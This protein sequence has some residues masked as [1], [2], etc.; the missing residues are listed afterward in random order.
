MRKLISILLII[1][2]LLIPA[3]AEELSATVWLDGVPSSVSCP[4]AYYNYQ[5]YEN[6][7]LGTVYSFESKKAG[8]NQMIDFSTDYKVNSG[9]GAGYIYLSFYYKGYGSFTDYLGNSVTGNACMVYPQFR[10]SYVLQDVYMDGSK[11]FKTNLSG[12]WIKKSVIMKINASTLDNSAVN[13]RFKINLSENF[14]IDIACPT[15]IYFNENVTEEEIIKYLKENGYYYNK[16][17]QSEEPYS[18][19]GIELTGEFYNNRK[20]LWNAGTTSDGAVKE[21][22]LRNWLN[23]MLPEIRVNSIL[24]GNYAFV[25][26]SCNYWNLT[27]KD[28]MSAPLIKDEN[29]NYLLPGDVAYSLFNAG[30]KSTYI[31]VD[32]IENMNVFK[33]HRGFVLISSNPIENVIDLTVNENGYYNSAFDISDAIGTITWNDI[34]PTE[35]DYEAFTS[36]WYE[37]MTYPEG[38]ESEFSDY[39]SETVSTAG[40]HLSLYCDNGLSPFSDIEIPDPDATQKNFLALEQVYSR[41]REMAI[42]YRIAVNTGSNA[43]DTKALKSAILN[44]LNLMHTKYY[45]NNAYRIDG[46]PRFTSFK[47]KLPEA[48]ADILLCMYNDLEYETLKKYAHEVLGRTVLPTVSQGTNERTDYTNRLWATVPYIKL[49]V[50]LKDEARINHAYRYLSQI[51]D[52]ASRSVENPSGL[53]GFYEDG[54]FVFHNNFAYNL[55]Y[56]KSYLASVAEFY[57]TTSGTVFDI[58]EIYGFDRMYDRIINSYLPFIYDFKNMKIVTGRE[59]AY[60]NA[61]TTVAACIILAGS[62]PEDKKTEI[63][64]H[65]KTVIEN[66]KDAETYLK[67]KTRF[68]TFTYLAY[69]TIVKKTTEFLNTLNNIESV[70]NDKFNKIYYNMDRVLHKTDNFTFALAMSS[71]RIGKYESS[72]TKPNSLTEWYTGDGMTYIHNKDTQYMS[73]WFETANPYKMPGTTVDSTVRSEEQTFNLSKEEWGLPENDFA[74]GVSNG[75]AGVAGMELGNKWVSGLKGRKSYFMLDNEII[76]MGTGISGG[77]GNAYTVVDNR[78][79]NGSED[80]YVNGALHTCNTSEIENPSSVWLEGNIGYIFSGENCVTINKEEYKTGNPHFVMSVQHGNEPE[81][82]KYLYTLLPNADL[83]ETVNYASNPGFTVLSHTNSLHAI[84]RKS[85]GMILANVFEPCELYG[86]YFKTPCSVLI[87]GNTL[88]ISDPTM[89]QNEIKLNYSKDITIDVSNI[90]GATY[91][92]ELPLYNVY[93]CDIT[94]DGTKYIGKCNF[95][96]NIKKERNISVYLAAYSK[97]RLIGLTQSKKTVSSNSSGAKLYVELPYPAEAIT[98]VKMYIW[99]DLLPL[100]TSILYTEN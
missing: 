27:E 73:S 50:L 2:Y 53:S 45:A 56:G 62:A 34:S 85:D 81:N 33:D 94:T 23:E 57:N 8:N 21:H 74:G 60:S 88:Y 13:L 5:E 70:G 58:S 65:I 90:K 25:E 67:K 69:P 24:N 37:D 4:E 17:L 95:D 42:G 98:Q 79:I 7:I 6:K 63:A 49:A 29:G 84:L 3:G 61:R 97:D 39:I 11:A 46:N 15:L 1:S 31:N 72:S 32:E 54:S 48:L 68:D 83:S 92:Y 28:V 43:V 100:T 52:N 51:F 40:K 96:N 36:S 93:N 14:K 19:Y 99:Q 20:N 59:N 38:C 78:K 22:T 64:S 91:K 44:A 86:F 12:S 10:F 26:N 82:G 18:K 89:K 76:L 35:S 87:D 75:T 77:Y 30:N 66:S 71:S 9:E 80:I 55:G 41:L 16:I 47:F